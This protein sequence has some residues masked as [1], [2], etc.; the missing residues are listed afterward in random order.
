MRGP[1]LKKG[2]EQHEGSRAASEDSALTKD[3]K[4]YLAES[5]LVCDFS[6]ALQLNKLA[7]K[8][9]INGACCHFNI[10]E[11]TLSQVGCL[12]ILDIYLIE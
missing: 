12:N 5:V 2:R 4:K 3:A 10:S 1:F 6:S 9:V 11:K 8:T 7:L